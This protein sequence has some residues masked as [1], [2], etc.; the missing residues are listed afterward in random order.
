MGASAARAQ[1]VVQ[2]DFADLRSRDK[3]GTSLQVSCKPIEMPAREAIPL[4]GEPRQGVLGISPS[5]GSPFRN[6]KYYRDLAE[7]HREFSH[8]CPVGLAVTNPSSTVAEQVVVTL[9]I[10]NAEGLSVLD[11]T[12]MPPPPLPNLFPWASSPMPGG[13]TVD[14]EVHLYGQKF[15]IRAELGSVQPGTTAWS[16]DAFY[17]GARESRTAIA[18]VTISADNLRVP[19][20]LTAEIVIETTPQR[21]DVQDIINLAET[22]QSD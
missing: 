21:L 19:V 3:L 14:V 4:Y 11:R 10:D 17:I 1:P 13:H 18:K 22:E 2:L 15:E 8:L 16:H 7:W 9:E 6:S 20:M 12:D 5:Y